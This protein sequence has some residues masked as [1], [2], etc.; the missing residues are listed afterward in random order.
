MLFNAVLLPVG[1]WKNYFCLYA[2]Q[3]FSSCLQFVKSNE[4]TIKRIFLKEAKKEAY[5]FILV[6]CDKMITANSKG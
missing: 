2:Q 6:H 1:M 3:Y 4:F 5:S